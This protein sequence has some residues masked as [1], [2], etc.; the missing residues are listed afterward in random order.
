MAFFHLNYAIEAKHSKAKQTKI[1]VISQWWRFMTVFTISAWLW[2]LY[3]QWNE[4][5]YASESNSFDLSSQKTRFKSLDS[6]L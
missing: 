6:M 1:N 5:I 2:W 4:Q 3:G